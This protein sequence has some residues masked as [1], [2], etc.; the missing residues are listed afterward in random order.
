M[1]NF[2]QI[3]IK[4]FETK[5]VKLIDRG[6]LITAGNENSFNT[7]TASWAGIGFLWQRPVAFIF[8]RPQRYTLQFV[9]REAVLTLSFFDETYRRALNI[10]GSKSGRNTDK[11]SEAGI[12]PV[13]FPAGSIAFEEASYVF[14]C[15]KLYADFLKPECFINC[16]IPK[17]IYPSNDF[18]K[19]FTLEI[20]QA[21]RRKV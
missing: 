17:E 20:T 8:I 10:C 2:E 19:M 4:D 14:E 18:H 5:P 7:M 1:N 12:T 3:S 13:K 9:E 21:W 11:V 15:K 16:N 6:M